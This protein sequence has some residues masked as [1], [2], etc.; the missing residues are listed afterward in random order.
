MFLLGVWKKEEEEGGGA[1][2]SI[3]NF[4]T[5]LERTSEVELDVHPVR[6]FQAGTLI[7]R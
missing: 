4:E 1:A 7:Q 2:L 5:K 3:R 6:S